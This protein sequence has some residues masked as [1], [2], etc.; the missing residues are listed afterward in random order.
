MFGLLALIQFLAFVEVWERWGFDAA[1]RERWVQLVIGVVGALWVLWT[2][3]LS[4]NRRGAVGREVAEL[5]RY[6][7]GTYWF[8][9]AIL[10]LIGL[11]TGAPYSFVSWSSWIYF[12]LGVLLIGYGFFTRRRTGESGS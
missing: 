12:L 5:R 7:A 1:L 4:P 3:L 6:G 8:C 10:V 2:Y 9:G 11:V